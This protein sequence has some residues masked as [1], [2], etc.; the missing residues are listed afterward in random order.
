MAARTAHCHGTD[1][2]GALKGNDNASKRPSDDVIMS[3]RLRIYAYEIT[4]EQMAEELGISE[5]T[6]YL[7]IPGQLGP[8]KRPRGPADVA[9]EPKRAAMSDRRQRELAKRRR[10]QA[11]LAELLA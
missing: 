11:E 3:Y 10:L 4:R 9:W 5:S 7:W 6:T 8:R 1:R 2:G